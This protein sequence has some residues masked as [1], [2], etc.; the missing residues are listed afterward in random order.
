MTTP[1]NASARYRQGRPCV[2]CAGTLRYVSNGKCTACVATAG[3]ARQAATIALRGTRRIGL[4]DGFVR[5][6]SVAHAILLY[7]HEAGPSQLAELDDA[8]PHELGLSVI[9]HRLVKHGFL[10]RAGRQAYRPRIRSGHLYA[11]DPPLGRI[12]TTRETT[13]QAQK[14]QRV[15]RRLRV[16]SVFEFRGNIPLV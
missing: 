11:L 1:N 15:D 5:F 7:V 8:L 12:R 6:G 3:A 13:S 9:T 16:P 14:R 4:R 10:H 2:H